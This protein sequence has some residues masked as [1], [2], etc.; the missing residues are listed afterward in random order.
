M[1]RWSV[2]AAV[3]VV[4]GAAVVTATYDPVKPAG[5]IVPAGAKTITVGQ[6]FGF[7]NMAKVM[8]HYNRATTA[9]ARLNDR[10]N[11]MTANLLGLKGMHA[12][13]QAAAQAEKN[14]PV[15]LVNVAS[16]DEMAVGM[17]KLARQIED[18]DREINRL[19]NNAASA[20]IT[21]LYDEVH[22]AAVELSKEHGLTA[23]LTYPDA[24]T[25]EEANSPQVKELK[26]KPPALHP[27]YLDPAADYTDELLERLNAKFAADGK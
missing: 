11:R 22:A 24:V 4:A 19:L 3:A 23:L 10:K 14:K 20:I 13:L 5:G 1:I 18:M 27:F 15:T 17:V 21:E 26:L 25:P 12:D 8:R 16:M 6:K 7:F 9:V 2:A